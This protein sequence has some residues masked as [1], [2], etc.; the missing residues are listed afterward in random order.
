MVLEIADHHPTFNSK[1]RVVTGACGLRARGDVREDG[2]DK[3]VREVEN[4]EN[5]M[6]RLTFSEGSCARAHTEAGLGRRGSIDGW[7]SFPNEVIRKP[8]RKH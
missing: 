4:C 5:G 6:D 2:K 8:T 1:P 3:L 7:V